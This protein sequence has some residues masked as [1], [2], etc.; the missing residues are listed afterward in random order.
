MRR[1]VGGRQLRLGLVIDL[2]KVKK[3]RYYV[4]REF[5][6]GGVRDVVKIP[7]AGYGQRGVPRRGRGA[8]GTQ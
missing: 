6:E 4:Q 2:T 5:T 7:C 1:G 3:D 8:K